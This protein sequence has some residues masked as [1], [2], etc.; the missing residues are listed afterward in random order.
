MAEIES[1][2]KGKAMHFNEMLHLVA[3]AE[4]RRMQVDIWAWEKKTGENIHYK[5]WLVHHD[6]WKGGY[7]RLRNPRNNQIRTIPEIFINRIN[8]YSI[9]L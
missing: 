1:K 4:E 7:I 5:N 6:Y 9:F 3:I 8:G 2:R